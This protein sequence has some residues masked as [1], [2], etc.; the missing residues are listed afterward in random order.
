[1]T[2]RLSPR[3]ILDRLVAFPTVSRDTN[4]PLIDWVEDYLDSHGVA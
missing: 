3:Q 2:A 4:L 1:M